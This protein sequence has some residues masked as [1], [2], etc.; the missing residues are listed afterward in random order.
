MSSSNV[1]LWR[2]GPTISRCWM[3][4]MSACGPHPFPARSPANSLVLLTGS[5]L[6]SGPQPLGRK[7][8]QLCPCSCLSGSRSMRSCS[9]SCCFLCQVG[10]FLPPLPGKF[11]FCLKITSYLGQTFHKPRATCLSPQSILGREKGLP[12]PAPLSARTGQYHR[13]TVCWKNQEKR[14]KSTK[15][16]LQNPDRLVSRPDAAQSFK[17]GSATGSFP[18]PSL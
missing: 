2:C 14:G 1:Y 16:C 18:A 4:Q 9:C 7:L 15:R 3:C 12:V 11:L 13:C 6:M 17:L 10:P 8:W 5:L